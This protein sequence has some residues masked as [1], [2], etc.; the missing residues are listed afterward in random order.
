MSNEKSG[1]GFPNYF[2][3]LQGM[4]Q[5]FAQSGGSAVPQFPLLDPKELERKIS[6]METV[7]VWL[8]AQS[9]AVELSIETMK[10]QRQWLNEM[11]SKSAE[12]APTSGPAAEDMAK[13]AG[14]FNPALWAWNMMQSQGAPAPAAPKARARTRRSKG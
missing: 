4:M 14:A 11:H 6:E 12:A 5:P 7:L 8:K 10:V 2:E 13:M 1:A 9:S 3:M